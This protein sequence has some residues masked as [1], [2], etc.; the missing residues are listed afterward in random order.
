MIQLKERLEFDIDVR[1]L[2][3]ATR[4]LF[5]IAGYKKKNVLILFSSR[6]ILCLWHNLYYFSLKAPPRQLTHLT[7]CV[8]VGWPA[9][10]LTSR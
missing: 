6:T 2:P 4:I 3:R 9:P 7:A 1:D 10:S 8:S 5:R